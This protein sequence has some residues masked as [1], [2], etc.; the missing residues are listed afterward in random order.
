M[1]KRVF[2]SFDYDYDI[3]IKGSLVGQAKLPDSPFEIMDM[4]IK[5][6]IASNWK[7]NARRR[8]KGCDCVIVLCG[9]HTASAKGVAA[10]L[11]ITQEEG[12]PYFLLRGRPSDPVQK[13]SPAKS[14]DKIYKWTWDNLKLLLSGAR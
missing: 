11:T 9:M 6:A 3:D 10:E 14:T 2:I 1:K 12:I 5:E 4:S 13:P 7:D 8:I